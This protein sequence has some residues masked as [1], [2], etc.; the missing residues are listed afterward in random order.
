METVKQFWLLVVDVW[1]KGLLETNLG[2]IFVALGIILG[3]VL[4]R[5]LFM[6]IIIG[7]LKS[8][9]A[10]TQTPLDDEALAVLER[11]VAFIPVVMGVYF[12]VDYLDL[13]GGLRVFD[14]RLVRSLIVLIIFW[15]FKNLVAP[16]S[17][18]LRQLERR[19]D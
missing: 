2:R 6:R 17:T 7:R 16:L 10:N 19:Y 14:D 18:M 5:N 4:I 9:A 13:S 3:A 1:Q 15:S 8:M 12:A 11:P